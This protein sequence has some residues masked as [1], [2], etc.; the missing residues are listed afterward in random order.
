MRRHMEKF[1]PTN[2]NTEDSETPSDEST[3]D[4]TQTDTD[5]TQTD[6]DQT[7]SDINDDSNEDTNM[8]S[9]GDSDID[10][11]MDADESDQELLTIVR[12]IR[13]ER[14]PVFLQKKQQHMAEGTSEAEAI[15]MAMRDMLRKDRIIFLDQY[16]ELLLTL[17]GLKKS[18]K[19]RKIRKIIKDLSEDEDYDKEEAIKYALEKRKFLFDDLF[20]KVQYE[21]SDEE[22]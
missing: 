4:Q 21:D 18:P 11:D 7:E 15:D 14:V 1:H 2:E 22:V 12:N 3:T 16:Q 13:N 19:H 20:N 8:D 9:D 10:S 17:E 5:Q 6:T